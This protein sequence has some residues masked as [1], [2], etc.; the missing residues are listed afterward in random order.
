MLP[1]MSTP[2]DPALGRR[3]QW[4]VGGLVGALTLIGC[5][6]TV[7][8]PRALGTPHDTPSR[9]RLALMADARTGSTNEVGPDVARVLASEM[10]T[11][12][13]AS[14]PRLP[15]R[16]NH[17]ASCKLERFCI[18]EDWS[19]R[20]DWHLLIAY[21]DVICD[22]RDASESVTNWRGLIRGR[23]AAALS[24]SVDF[25]ERGSRILVDRAIADLGREL[26]SD[27]LVASLDDRPLATERIFRQPEAK[28]VFGG[29][30]DAPRAN[31]ALVQD[32]ERARELVESTDK[33]PAAMARHWNAIGLLAGGGRPWLGGIRTNLS[34]D[35]LVRFFQYK[36]LARHASPATLRELERASAEEPISILQ[37]FA[38]DAVASSGL[39]PVG[40][41]ARPQRVSASRKTTG[42]TTNP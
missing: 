34:S 14:A 15:N 13:S 36:A 29:V 21:A 20:Q 25:P 19:R 5:A 39:A 12:L 9:L 22:V 18:Q 35:A 27:L 17:V 41:H 31:L 32:A 8:S 23:A 7:P 3:A 1:A 4:V 37:V 10:A 2:G 38:L 26:A 11:E 24:P 30:L 42:T 6:H 28:V 40:R 33:S 16:P